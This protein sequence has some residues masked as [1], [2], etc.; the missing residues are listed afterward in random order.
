MGELMVLLSFNS[1]CIP[2]Y[3]RSIPNGV[4]GRNRRALRITR[5]C[6][7]YH[8]AFVGLRGWWGRRCTPGDFSGG[9]NVMHVTFVWGF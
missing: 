5:L 9:E 3:A 2:T 1:R 7:D 8:L 6:D 4:P